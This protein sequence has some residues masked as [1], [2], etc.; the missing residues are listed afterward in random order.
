MEPT[1]KPYENLSIPHDT[2]I[3]V[4]KPKNAC[5]ATQK[6]PYLGVFLNRRGKKLILKVEYCP[7]CASIYLPCKVYQKQ[8][9][10]LKDYYFIR[11]KTGKPTA[12]ML[13][14]NRPHTD[15]TAPVQESRYTPPE[16]KT[17]A[18]LIRALKYPCQGGRCSGK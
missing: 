17:P 7:T 3:Y 1:K 15:P 6:I 4:G 13:I 18:Y 14:L 9:A 5:C 2:T 11:T 10:Q 12:E 16:Y 8:W